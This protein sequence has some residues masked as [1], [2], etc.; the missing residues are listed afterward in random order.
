MALTF[1]ASCGR[2][3]TE[4]SYSSI[5]DEKCNAIGVKKKKSVVN[6]SQNMSEKSL[7]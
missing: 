7:F 4:K 2:I 1:I 6:T 3:S 5:H